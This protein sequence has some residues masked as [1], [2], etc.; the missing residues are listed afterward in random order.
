[1]N[2]IFAAMLF[3]V[4]GCNGRPL[5]LPAP[6]DLSASP[7]A[8]D[9]AD[10][11]FCG[12]PRS[13]RAEINGETGGMLSVK[14]VSLAQDCCGMGKIVFGGVSRDPIT[15]NWSR[16]Q[17]WAEPNPVTADLSHLPPGWSLKL[18]SG[19]SQDPSGCTEIFLDG[20]TGTLSIATNGASSTVSLCLDVSEYPGYPHGL[21]HRVRLWAP[22]IAIK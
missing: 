21:L 6:E 13:P 10:P 9:L 4:L 11:P 8:P 20:F 2:Y 18:S 14:A 5:S 15:L 3:M 16:Q 22:N 7:P 1:M 12:D 19:C 17:Y